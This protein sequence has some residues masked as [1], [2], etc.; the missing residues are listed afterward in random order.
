MIQAQCRFNLDK[1]ETWL[2]TKWLG[3]NDTMKYVAL[4]ARSGL[5]KDLQKAQLLEFDRT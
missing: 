1:F 3:Y 2:A 4:K 5:I